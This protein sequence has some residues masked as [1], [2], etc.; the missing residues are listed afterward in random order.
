MDINSFEIDIDFFNDLDSV[1]YE[2]LVNEVMFKSFYVMSNN[3][4]ICFYWTDK[5]KI[6]SKQ[7][8][9]QQTF[10]YQEKG[11]KMK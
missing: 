1:I 2:Y 7:K 6:N 5:N 3:I 10:Y 4:R 8:V 9:G 11:V